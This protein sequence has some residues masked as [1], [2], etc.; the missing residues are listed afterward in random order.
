[1][2]VAHT[3]LVVEEHHTAVEVVGRTVVEVAGHTAEE[4]LRSL[5]VVEHRPV[6]R[7]VLK[8]LTPK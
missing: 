5:A 4:D 8:R 3:G 1:M 7:Q 6:I 2:V